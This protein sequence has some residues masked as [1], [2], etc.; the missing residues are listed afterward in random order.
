M[1]GD[2]SRFGRAPGT[3]LSD[4]LRQ[5]QEQARR[6]PEMLAA[7]AARAA[8]RGTLS[9]D[10]ANENLANARNVDAWIAALRTVP[11]RMVGGEVLPLSSV[12]EEVLRSAIGSMNSREP[13]VLMTWPARDVC[14]SAV[15]SLLALA[16]V[17]VCPEAEIELYGSKMKSFERPRGFKALIYP[18]ARTTHESARDIQVDRD[19]LHRT[20]LAHVT[21]H[22][23]GN[24]DGRSLQDY[25]YV[26]S[27]VG[28]LNGKGR[29]GTVRPEFEHPTLDEIMPHGN[30]EGSAH[31]HGTLLWRT[32][33]R[34][35]LKAHNTVRTH[36]DIGND[37]SYYLYGARKGDEI[38]F[39][40]IRGGLD[41]IIFDLT[42]TGRGR[43]GDDWVTAATRIYKVMRKL[44]PD[45]GVIAVT[46]DPWAFDKARFE[47]FS[48]ISVARGRSVRPAMSRTITSLNSSALVDADSIRN[49]S[50]CGVVDAKGFNGD[51]RT[52]ADKL[53]PVLARLRRTRDRD[54][55]AAVSDIISKLRRAA[56]LPGSL[57]AFDDYLEDEHGQTAAI[58]VM[59]NYRITKQV[60]Y[61]QDPASAA[62]V[63]G[64]DELASPLRDAQAVMTSLARATPMSF[65]LAAVVGS[66]LN[67]SSKAL[68]MFRKQTLAEFAMTALCRQI[69][70]LQSRLD[71]EM[72]VFSGPGGLSDVAGL[73]VSERNKFKRIYV[74]A[75]ARD[76]VLT[77]F[78][79]DWLPSE[80]YILADG[81][82]LS[83]SSRD[84]FRLA[85]QIKEPEIASRLKKYATAADADLAG[86]GISPIKLTETPPLPEELQFPSE[87]IINL[88]GNVGKG[89]GDLL[90]FTMDSGQKI[91]A[92]PGTALVRLDR[93]KSME[94][95]RQIE[96]KDVKTAESICVISSG[97]ID[98]ARILL[99]IH[100]NASEAIR[101]YH[102]DVVRRFA[103]LP[104][105]SDNDR[106]RTII[107]RMGDPNLQIPTVRRW[108]HLEK[109][110]HA[111]LHEVVTQA[112]Q[113]LDTFLKFTAA[114]GINKDLA[115]RFWHWGVK[116]QR[117]S[118]MKAGMEFHDA[119]RNILTDPHAA[120]AFAG[121]AKRA[122]EIAKLLRLA[123]EYV[124]QVISV[125]KFKP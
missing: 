117:S 42:R 112:P 96:A 25:H 19:Y 122:S 99:S 16:D 115:E 1:K 109:Q 61:L 18:Y 91:I 66:I 105:Y 32:S 31:P 123:E 45:S 28:T 49:W 78:A 50:G 8:A 43:L 11:L 108:I 90:E 13:T 80:V 85:D 67:S 76:G 58:D 93:S 120:L 7:Q 114:L 68:F 12:Y 119:Y 84:A 59:D 9:Q 98:R 29:D 4:R 14:L 64:G 82:T 34:T 37:A 70:E 101:G 57:R 48:E 30:C 102:E 83:F 77:F 121:D 62:Y 103:T 65:V 87:S 118:R 116:A 36:T 86:L 17:A 46:E 3:S 35:D 110:L 75:P 72:I 60:R 63:I 73:P 79:R 10:P 27:R 24:E 6:R 52:V 74:V 89:D 92:R 51:G 2:S 107:E 125:R 47:I 113:K 104:G 124:C 41:L 39:R 22:A 44:F 69:P 54:G 97:F 40:K 100:A 81:D 26:L 53:R 71:K 106:V 94:T 33:S 20:H 21:R 56:S 5:Q 95:F 88:A 15:T 111:P 23:S 38:T 55:A